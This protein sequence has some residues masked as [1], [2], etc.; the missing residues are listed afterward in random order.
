M[1]HLDLGL[2]RY[3]IEYMRELLKL[4]HNNSLINVIDQRLAAIPRYLGLKIFSNGL[5][6]IARLTASEYRNLMKVMIF[7]VDNLYDEKNKTNK[8]VN[9]FIKN[10]DL[11]KLYQSWNDMYIISRYEK[12]SESDLV[13]FKVS[14]IY[15]EFE[16][17]Y[18]LLLKFNIK[19]RMQCTNGQEDLFMLLN[20][21]LLLN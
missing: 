3:Q 7:V 19:F 13:I 17:I 9:N 8:T 5:Q 4:Q 21:F 15:L 11:V 2:F 14:K 6:S 12:F 1:H 16:L 20:S 10:N 18:L